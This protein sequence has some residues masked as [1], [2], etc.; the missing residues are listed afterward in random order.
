M[1]E[2]DPHSLWIDDHDPQ[3][4]RVSWQAYFWTGN[5]GN[6]KAWAVAILRRLGRCTWRCRWCRDDLPAYLRAD[7]LYC[8]ESCRKQ[9]ARK[10]RAARS[11][12][13]GSEWAKRPP[14][15]A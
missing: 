14:H 10:R 11:E 12:C 3:N 2:P 13:A 1:P 9:A 15:I 5:N 7:A 8:R 6:R 4:A